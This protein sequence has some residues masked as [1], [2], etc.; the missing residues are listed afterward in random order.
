MAETKTT[1]VKR[2]KK[3]IAVAVAHVNSSFNNS[4]SLESLTQYFN[5]NDDKP[6]DFDLKRY[7]EEHA[8]NGVDN[9]AFLSGHSRSGAV[10]SLLAK[11]LKDNNIKIWH[12]Y[13]YRVS[14]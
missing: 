1:R 6:I 12:R 7:M 14:T 3:N 8:V 11:N 9:L 4:N 13:C 2:E 5:T 10:G